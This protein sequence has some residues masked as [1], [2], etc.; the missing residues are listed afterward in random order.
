MTFE[1]K[2]KERH[3]QEI[4]SEYCGFL[5]LDMDSY[6]KIQ[7][8]LMLEQIDL[9]SKCP[10]GQQFLNGKTPATIDAFRAAVPLTTYEDYADTLL[11]KKTDML[12]D[13]PIVWI[14]TTWEGGRHPVKVAPYTQSML[15]TYKSNIIACLILATSAK[16]GSFNVRSTDRILYALAPLPY[17]TG[18]LPLALGEEIGIEFLPPVKDAVQMSFS[19]RNKLGFK[20]GMKKGI[21]YF[22][23]L[24]S[25]A[26]YVS[27]SL[28]SMGK[29]GGKGSGAG[30]GCS[31][32]M[33]RRII[34]AKYRCHQEKRDLIP[35]DL[36]T[37]KGFMCAGTDNRCYKDDL[38][39]L[40]GI[41]PMEIFA[42]TEPSCVGTETW[43]RNGM[44]FFPDT[45]FYE[46]IP[47]REMERNLDDPSYEPKTYLMDEVSAG[48][49]YELVISVLKGGAFMRYRVGDVYRCVGVENSEDQTR[50]PRFEYIDRVPTIIDI[51]GF[52]RISENS[53]RSAIALSGLH[54]EDWTALKEYTNNRPY[55]HLYIEM[56]ENSLSHQAVGKELLK[57]HLGVYFKYIDEDYKDLKK[58]LQMD[59]LD[60]TILKCGTFS[61]Y[62]AQNGKRIRRLNPNPYEVKELLELQ[63]ADYGFA[64]KGAV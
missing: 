47:E 35:K 7:K 10:L 63:S 43:T 38:E 30:F 62:A 31:P 60:I 28:S 33:L 26:Y 27:L 40:W 58:L 34:S 32:K 50:I 2:L 46:F 15:E 41:R 61:R 36:F 17:A 22:F 24:G 53:I 55:L 13:E 12:P 48:E 39:R 64:R 19:Q 51:A 20:L 11:Q 5:D 25:V 42:G 45:C 59:P 23:G 21:E 18:L 54:I 52:T 3:T 8:R 57:E 9:W 56:D 1:E 49:K 44:Y 16:K 29:S 6:M 14:Q 37:L 4:W